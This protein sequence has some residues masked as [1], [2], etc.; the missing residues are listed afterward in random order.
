[1]WWPVKNDNDR[2]RRAGASWTDTTRWVW[3]LLR[4]I[5]RVKILT[6]GFVL[7]SVSRLTIGLCGSCVHVDNGTLVSWTCEV[8]K[9]WSIH[10][11]QKLLNSATLTSAL[12]K[13]SYPSKLRSI[14]TLRIPIFDDWLLVTLS[15]CFSA[16]LTRTA[17]RCISHLSITPGMTLAVDE[18][19]TGDNI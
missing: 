10:S 18:L 3:V 9:C 11:L 14:K 17:R 19:W 1:M 15:G 5:I 16:H 2:R 6:N 12:D 13:N 7:M 8:C 4:L